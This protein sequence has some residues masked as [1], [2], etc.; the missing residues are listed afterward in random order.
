MKRYT[1]AAFTIWRAKE[2]ER[3]ALLDAADDPTRA[4]A[5]E[6]IEKGG[7]V[8][9]FAL[10]PHRKWIGVSHYPRNK[11]AEAASK[12]LD[13][14]EGQAALARAGLPPLNKR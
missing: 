11:K 3:Q 12:W 5:L 13:S 4:Q 1:H 9:S 14:P 6:L 10:P 2:A 7:R 8:K